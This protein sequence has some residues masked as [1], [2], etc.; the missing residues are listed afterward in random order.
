MVAI[1]QDDPYQCLM[2]KIGYSVGLETLRERVI[3]LTDLYVEQRELNYALFRDL[4]TVKFERDN[5][6]SI[7]E[8]AN[9]YGSLN[10]LKLYGKKLRVLPNLDT[11]SILRRLLS[12][13]Q[14]A[15]TSAAKVV[16]IQSVLE[17]DGDI[18]INGLA[19]DFDTIRFK[20]LLEN[21]I[22]IKRES[23]GNV[24]KSQGALRRIYDIIDIK[25]QL[26]NKGS[27]S[28]EPGKLKQ[29]RFGRRTEPL[30]KYVR[31]TAPLSG[32]LD[33]KVDIPSDYLIK[34]PRTRK[35]WAEDLG[36]FENK[37]KTAKGCNLL[38]TL[39]NNL[40]LKQDSGCYVFWPYSSDLLKLRIQPEE[41]DA[42]DLN[43]WKLLCAIAQGVGNVKIDHY[44]DKADYTEVIDLLRVF[45]R[46]YR[47]GNTSLASIRHQLPLYVVHPCL[48][49]LY[50]AKS[51]DIP[52][53]PQILDAE[54]KKEIRK[55]QKIIIRGTEGGII[56][57]EEK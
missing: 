38:L 1:V 47:E 33:V 49:A 35:G 54:A 26:S 14:K 41:I 31:R 17:A 19:A 2:R 23:I 53:L 13:D 46:Q 11:L 32:K 37:H 57:N 5:E 24:I 6:R 42:V 9:V 15:F 29:S 28:G 27:F 4:V 40:R 39:E 7:R 16:L 55:V 45:H 44:D 43:P 21:M 22:Q 10:L 8:F 20:A 52:P 36:L 12:D 30:S 3:A 48:V 25:T 51:R 34:V 50:V 56:F 18:F